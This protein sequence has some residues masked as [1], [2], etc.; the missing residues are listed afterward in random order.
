MALPSRYCVRSDDEVSERQ[1]ILDRIKEES[2]STGKGAYDGLIRYRKDGKRILLND[3][4][5]WNV[6]DTT[7]T[8]N[9]SDAV[10]EEAATK[11]NEPIVIGQAVCIKQVDFLDEQ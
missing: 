8:T 1:Q 11:K 4:T 2:S 6:F 9:K 10:N 7:T 3:V 5:L